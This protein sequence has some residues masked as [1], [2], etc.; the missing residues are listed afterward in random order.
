MA[1]AWR[2]LSR[3]L[4]VLLLPVIVVAALWG[5]G[6]MTS[7]T[8]SQREAVAIM[9]VRPPLAAGENGFELLRA[10]PPRPAEGA[11]A[12]PVCGNGTSCIDV[13]EASPER[14]A[15]AIAAWR[16]WLEAS[17][18]ALRAPAFRDLRTDTTVAGALPAYQGMV[19][20][21]L[22]RAFD[23]SAGQTTAAL[24]ALCEDTQGA[25]RRATTP[26][27]LIDGMLGVA[28]VRENA[29]LIA[30][31]RRRAPQDALPASCAALAV[32]PDP[33]VEGTLCPA[34]RGEWQWLTRVMGDLET[35]APSN[36]PAWALPLLHDPEWLLARTAERYAP[37]CSAAA[38]DAARSDRPTAFAKVV[39]RWVDRIAYPV[40]V[41]LDSV[42][43]PGYASYA[44]QQLDYLAMR[45]LLGAF[46]QMEA[47]G[48][49]LTAQQRF[50]A[51][52]ASQREGPRP[53]LLS[54][55]GRSIAVPLRSA[56]YVESGSEMRL[57]LPGHGR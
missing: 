8:A 16:P 4:L 44:E 53:L 45:R 21:R 23:F 20:S 15:A 34:M 19:Q 17:A 41:I 54:D 46:L 5:Y 30:D 9:Q 43:E 10:L 11:P 29:L 39:P 56:R 22:L 28:I 42:A 24:E 26:D 1:T 52:P 38:Q 27:I 55:D 48:V 25:V 47:M 40:S 36:A 51:L 57:V 49:S 13:I 14:S 7:P 2:W 35:Q 33:G 6:R 50:D 37:H 31:M 32:G 12:L 3:I 18:R